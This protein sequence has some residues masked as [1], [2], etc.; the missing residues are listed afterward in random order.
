M[1]PFFDARSIS[2]SLSLSLFILGVI[3][4]VGWF[5]VGTQYNIRKGHDAMHWLQDGL[6]VVGEKT[7]L[8]WLGSSVVELKIQQAKPPFRTA[9]VLVVLEPRD[10]AP[11]WAFA[12]L[13]GRRDLF[14]FRANLQK[15][16]H[17]EIEAFDPTCW[18][19]R[20][21]A[22]Q[23]K[24]DQWTELPSRPPLVAYVPPQSPVAS[25]PISVAA[26]DACPLVRLAIH[27]AEPHL[28]VHWRLD[29]LRK[30]SAGEV[31]DTLHRLAQR[32]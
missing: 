1:Q 19:A 16:P 21:L 2:M 22:K 29:A 20:G 27:R 5:A 3:L 7:N 25:D 32:T 23:C 8:R 11:L 30:H 28:E 6:P 10:V 15:Q 24:A 12:R 13:R 18:S 31:F 14:I 4:V 26:L 9:T 17:S